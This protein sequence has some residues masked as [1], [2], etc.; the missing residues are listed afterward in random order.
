[1]GLNWCYTT[2]SRHTDLKNVKLTRDILSISEFNLE[3]IYIELNVF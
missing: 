3:T 2:I 1:M